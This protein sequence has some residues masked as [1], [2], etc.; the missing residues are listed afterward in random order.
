MNVLNHLMTISYLELK[1]EL[2]V[3]YQIRCRVFQPICK[4]REVG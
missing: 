4:R 1:I 3:A 2:E